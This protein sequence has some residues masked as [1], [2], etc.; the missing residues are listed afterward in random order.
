MTK[1][2]DRYIVVHNTRTTCD[3]FEVVDTLSGI[4]HEGSSSKSWSQKIADRMNQEAKPPVTLVVKDRMDFLKL[5]Y[6]T[7][8]KITDATRIGS[9]EGLVL[10]IEGGWWKGVLTLDDLG[11]FISFE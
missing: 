5:S 3:P 8:C 7:L 9:I 1:T 11:N 2:N 6:Y 4:V 10:S